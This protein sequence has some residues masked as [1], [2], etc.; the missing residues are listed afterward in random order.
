MSAAPLPDRALQSAL[1]FAVM[2]AAVASKRR[3]AAYYPPGLKSVLKYE[4]LSGASLATARK[5]VEHDELYMRVLGQAATPEIVDEVG[6][7]WLTRPVGWEQAAADAWARITAERAAQD[8]AGELRK[9]QRRRE[10]A[11]QAA[12][13]SRLEVAELKEQV[14]REHDTAAEAVRERDRLAGELEALQ[15]RV[16]E[17]E[18]GMA[19]REAGSKKVAEQAG[20]V[21]DE[22]T[23]LR[24]RLAATEAA[25][26]AALA[27]RADESP[28]GHD[29]RVR[30]L[31]LEALALTGAGAVADGG[32]RPRRRAARSPL[33]IPGGVYGNSE[34]AA[35]HLLRSPGVVVLVDGY[36]VAKLG[37]PDLSLERQRE[38]C[39]DI[40]ETVA[41]RWGTDLHV[42]FDGADVVGSHT[43]A[44]RLVR[45]VYSP[46][47][48]L[49]DDVLRAEVAALDPARA[50][51]V[52]T[53]DQAVLT[54]VK[55]QG[56]NTVSS[57]TFLAVA[58]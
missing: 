24:E 11:E 34:A 29:P 38:R 25:R 40:A 58:R 27:A 54:D 33:P 46:E 17:L 26:D 23:E 9:E 49:A 8:E 52:V 39:I 13:R 5:A 45:V 22:V 42:V 36:N 44:R 43:R 55:A 10:A 3:P 50:V 20:A 14:A 4:K 30:E 48:V 1:E 18:R 6:M 57:D 47:G 31:L 12:A 19:K 41:R 16:R 37:W 32:K 28:G 7:L 56:A 51:V 53:N 21:A 2:L 15:Q 35:E